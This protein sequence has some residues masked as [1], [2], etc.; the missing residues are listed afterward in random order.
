MDLGPLPR[1][2]CSA[3]TNE[4]PFQ[5]GHH[6][7]CRSVGAW[8]AYPGLVIYF[9]S[10]PQSLTIRW[11]QKIFPTTLAKNSM[12]FSCVDVLL[13]TLFMYFCFH[14][15]SQGV[16]RRP[17]DSPAHQWVSAQSTAVPG[18][19]SGIWGP[20]QFHPE[21]LWELVSAGDQRGGLAVCKARRALT[22]ILSL[23]FLDSF[24]SEFLSRCCHL[25]HVARIRLGPTTWP[26]P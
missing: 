12:L 20:S 2:S 23:G 5:Q 13:F 16:L 19:P 24:L 18:H 1:C 9:L 26:M 14:F 25:V 6:L 15:I 22:P 3:L 8:G 4:V 7:Q 10:H 21:V 17:G 11:N